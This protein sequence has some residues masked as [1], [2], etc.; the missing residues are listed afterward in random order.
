MISM[1]I[2]EEC[3]AIR[4]GLLELV[5]LSRRTKP[6]PNATPQELA[7]WFDRRDEDAD[8]RIRERTALSTLKDRLIE[9]QKLTGHHIALPI[10][11]SGLS[12]PN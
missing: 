12:N 8:R 1:P 10:S 4:R 9:H 11:P 6:G 3:D 2:C 5:E 7:E